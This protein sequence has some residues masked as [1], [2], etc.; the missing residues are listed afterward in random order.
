MRQYLVLDNILQRE[1]NITQKRNKK[2]SWKLD[3]D[4]TTIAAVAATGT[5][6]TTTK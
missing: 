1:K 4:K 3:Y 5:T 2:K 6:I